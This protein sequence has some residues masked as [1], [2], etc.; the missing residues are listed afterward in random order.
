V[1]TGFGLFVV[2]VDEYYDQPTLP[3]TATSERLAEIL[4]PYGAELW[5]PPQP[6]TTDAIRAFLHRWSTAE[7]GPASSFVYWV[8]HG[9]S[10]GTEQLLL[11]SNSAVEY[12]AGNA[13]P[14]AEIAGYLRRRWTNRVAGEDEAWTVIVLDCCQPS[15]GLLNILSVLTA[16][17]AS[18]PERFALVAVASGASTVGRFGEALGAALAVKEDND[19]VIGL[20][21]LL[22]EVSRRLEQNLAPFNWLPYDAALVNPR[23]TSSVLTMNVGLLQEWRA[24]VHALPDEV[25]SHFLGKAQSAELGELAWHFSGRHDETSHVATWL[26]EKTSGL[27]VVTGEP[28]AGKSALLGEVVTLADEAMSAVL[29]KAGLL[30]DR[31]DRERPPAGAFDIVIHLTG[32]TLADVVSRL[33]EVLPDRPAAGVGSLL[34]TLAATEQPL[35][36]LADALDESQEPI[37]IAEELLRPLAQLPHIRVVVGSRRSLDEGPDLPDPTSF[38]L[39]DALGVSVEN[40]LFVDRDPGA[41]AD[42][43][44]RRLTGQA[45]VT[46][47]VVADVA[48][49]VA[50]VDQPFLFVHLVTEEITAW[51]ATGTPVNLDR[52]FSGRHGDIFGLAM[53]RL[54]SSSP[55]VVGLLRALAFARGRGAPRTDRVWATM[56]EAVTPGLTVGEEDVDAA[57][58]L[59]AAYVTLDG[60]AGQ[61]VYRLAHR[62]F[63]EYFDSRT[64]DFR[65]ET[66]IGAA[67]LAEVQGAGGWP[68]AN[69]YVLLHQLEHEGVGASGPVSTD[70]GYLAETLRRFGIDRLVTILGSPEP[71]A[72][73]LHWPLRRAV[74]SARVALARDPEQLAAQLHARLQG[75]TDPALVRL[76]ARLPEIAPP[77]WLR[78]RSP[79]LPWRSDIETTQDFDG[80]VRAVAFGLVG[81]TTVLA[82]AEDTRLRLWDPRAGAPDPQVIDNGDDRII[83][84]GLG[85]RRGRAVAA[86]ASHEGNVVLRDLRSGEELL[87][88]TGVH[89]QSLCLGRTAGRNVIAGANNASAYWWDVDTG[90]LLGTRDLGEGLLRAAV[91]PTDTGIVIAT[92]DYGRFHA[93]LLDGSGPHDPEPDDWAD[94]PWPN[95]IDSILGLAVAQVG[96]RVLVVASGRE[97]YV[98]CWAWRGRDADTVEGVRTDFAVRSVAVAEIDGSLVVA[99]A[100][101]SGDNEGDRG[102]TVAVRD[103]LHGVRDRSE[104]WPEVV[105]ALASAREGPVALHE[106]AQGELTLHRVPGY[107]VVDD[108]PTDAA[109]AHVLT[110][111]RHPELV[112]THDG[113]DGRR[114]RRLPPP[115]RDSRRQGP[116]Q[117]TFRRAK[118]ESWD[119]TASKYGVFDGRAVLATGSYVGVAWV[120]DL[121]T[122]EAVAGPFADVPT[123][124]PATRAYSKPGLPRVLSLSLGDVDGRTLLGTVCDGRTNLWDVARGAAV[125][126]PQLSRARTID[127]A[128]VGDR[129]VLALGNDTGTVRLWDIRPQPA[130][131]LAGFTLD[132]EVRE[133]WLVPGEATLVVKRGTLTMSVFDYS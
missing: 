34:R 45:G 17:P 58:K 35:T 84:M 63:V 93:S 116:S 28:G 71:L 18:M 42:Y 25:R 132:G 81:D 95:D 74:R 11:A 89:L 111:G 57:L 131:H 127:I 72:R 1:E 90:A 30:S 114:L 62:T 21:S 14:A 16:K 124:I 12:S 85:T 43:A 22:M 59:A 23:A 5:G 117:R 19:Q 13:V 121:E 3:S 110:A 133:V 2:A 122:G 53:E 67:L 44:R 78:A 108:R 128:G 39:L 80:K 27:L 75:E 94:D 33:A 15:L 54:G 26:K 8:G 32:K 51:A 129:V 105:I 115:P 61:S 120:W 104:L 88:L 98:E 119:A 69:S 20:H 10:D 106:G 103:L 91:G 130:E 7:E 55:T 107:E 112:F 70:P 68:I 36:I 9:E 41:M 102:G 77:V 37:V 87:R 97:H 60:E 83:A 4:R 123:A 126:A 64:V 56:A 99:A 38:E 118:P 49:R 79:G 24:L 113:P 31:P 86:L 92:A 29:A 47:A 48:A 73:P 82:V 125:E 101:D 6:T 52:L 50:V 66:L 109:V 76:V 100:S 40:T 96:A 65:H 46:D